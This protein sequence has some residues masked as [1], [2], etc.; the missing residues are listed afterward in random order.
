[1]RCAVNFGPTLREQAYRLGPGNRNEADI[2][3][4][5]AVG[6]EKYA[7][8]RNIGMKRADDWTSPIKERRGLTL[9]LADALHHQSKSMQK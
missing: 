6:D 8:H 3:Q 9:Y 4:D 1:M 2:C 5:A 7:T